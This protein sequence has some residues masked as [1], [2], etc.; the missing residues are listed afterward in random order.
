MR[1]K[2][3]QSY[4]QANFTYTWLCIYIN[5]QRDLTSTEITIS[6]AM[7]LPS[8]IMSLNISEYDKVTVHVSCLFLPTDKN[9]TPDVFCYLMFS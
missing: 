2:H 1:R 4:T 6:W 3:Y 5:L 9:T 7:Y 8:Q